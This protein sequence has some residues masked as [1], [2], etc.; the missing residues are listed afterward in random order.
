MNQKH[1]YVSTVLGALLMLGD[2]AQAQEETPPN[3]SS[4]P[5]CASSSKRGWIRK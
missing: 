5:A 3:P 1:T 4:S 2:F